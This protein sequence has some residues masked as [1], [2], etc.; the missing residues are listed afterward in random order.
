M[1]RF[2]RKAAALVAGLG[3]LAA[4][5]SAQAEGRIRIA[6]Q[7]GIV[8]LLLNVAQEQKLVEKHARAAGIDAQV[9]WVKLSGGS[10]VNDALLSGNIEIAGAGVGPLLTLWDRTRGRQNVKGVASLGNF[11]YYLV[12]NNPDVKSIADFTDK[13]RIALP[14][15]GVSVQSRVLQLASAKLWGDKEFN[16]LDRISVAVPHPDATLVTW[17]TEWLNFSNTS[18]VFCSSAP[19]LSSG[20]CAIGL[21]S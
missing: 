2:T 1:N 16:R 12:S 5:L 21:G 3:L 15:V 20:R 9:E 10:A 11:P 8:Y 17:T 18:I 13:D 14:A 19:S 4:S 6:E 7:F